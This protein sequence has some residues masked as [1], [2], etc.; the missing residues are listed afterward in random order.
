MLATLNLV[1]LPICEI[2]YSHENIFDSISS[3][4]GD[5][6]GGDIGDDIGGDIVL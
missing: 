6:I 4:H 2:D 1:S 5:D 3:S